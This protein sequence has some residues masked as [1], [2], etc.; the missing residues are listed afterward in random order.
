MTTKL[1]Q[2]K[3]IKDH[4]CDHLKA[5]ALEEFSKGGSFKI[6]CGKCHHVIEIYAAGYPRNNKDL[7]VV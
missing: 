5:R 6:Q 3:F 4:C 2:E 1:D 7:G